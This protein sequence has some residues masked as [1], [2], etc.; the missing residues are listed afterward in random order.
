MSKLRLS[1]FAVRF[2]LYF[3]LSSSMIRSPQI[4]LLLYFTMLWDNIL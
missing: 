1:T 3:V 4:I 2:F